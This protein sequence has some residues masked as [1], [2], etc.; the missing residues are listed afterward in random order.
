PPRSFP[1]AVRAGRRWREGNRGS[2]DLAARAN[3]RE[4]TGPMER[5]AFFR[6]EFIPLRDANVNVMTH[7]FMYG[8]GCFEGIR[9]YW[10]EE[11]QE[12]YLFRLAEHFRRLLGSCRILQIKPMYSVAELCE[13]AVE[14]VRRNGDRQ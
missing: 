12:M 1:S 8:T 11:H 2:Y 14:L 13:L 6:G 3:G 10:C 9:G 7:A 4:R 5:Q